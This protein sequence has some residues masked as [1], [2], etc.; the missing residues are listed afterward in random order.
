MLKLEHSPRIFLYKNCFWIQP[1]PR[2]DIL[3][4]RYYEENIRQIKNIEKEYTHVDAIM[5]TAPFTR[6]KNMIKSSWH[7]HSARYWQWPIRNDIFRLKT[8]LWSRL[9]RW[10]KEF[11][12]GITV[13]R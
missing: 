8:S 13:V 2:S 4:E 6:H 12:Y 11:P 1:S 7:R 5:W 9:K 3:T 10:W